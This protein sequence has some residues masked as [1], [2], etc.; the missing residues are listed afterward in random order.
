VEPLPIELDSACRV[1]TARIPVADAR[2][3]VGEPFVGQL[4]DGGRRSGRAVGLPAFVVDLKG[5]E[6][7]DRVGLGARLKPVAN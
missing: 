4:G 6:L 3:D 1:A 5:A 7:G 2:G